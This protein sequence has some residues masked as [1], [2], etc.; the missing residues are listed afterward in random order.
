[1]KKKQIMVIG[2]VL[3]T[4]AIGSVVYFINQPSDAC[5]A[6]DKEQHNC[7]PAG[8]CTPPGDPREGTVDCRI[9]NY[10]HTFDPSK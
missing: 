7:V 8:S 4:L 10:D 5:T 9:K 1:M 2:L 6:K 3:L